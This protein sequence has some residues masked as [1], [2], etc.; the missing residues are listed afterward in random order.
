MAAEE[1]FEAGSNVGKVAIRFFFF[2]GTAYQVEKYILW[3]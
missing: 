3:S 2:K 1:Y